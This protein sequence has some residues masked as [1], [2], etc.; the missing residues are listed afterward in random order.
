MGK[1]KQAINKLNELLY[2][3]P[4]LT[5][6]DRYNS[7][8]WLWKD[9]VKDTIENFFSKDSDEYKRFKGS[10][11]IIVNHSIPEK[12]RYFKDLTDD[13]R[14]IK[15]IINRQDTIKK[16]RKLMNLSK[17]IPNKIWSELKDFTARIIAIFFAEK[18]K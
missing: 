12:E 6:F 14:K 3:I 4:G 1:K 5:K 7:E 9:E 2:K 10:G 18:T 15:S 17:S 8:Y 13:E 11:L 16:Y